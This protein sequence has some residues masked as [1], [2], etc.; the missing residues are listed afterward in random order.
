LRR[1]TRVA[2]LSVE[3]Q[4][5]A[6]PQ[7]RLVRPLEAASDE[8]ELFW[9]VREYGGQRS[10]CQSD[11]QEADLIVVQRFFPMALSAPLLEALLASGVPVIFEL[12]DLLTELTDRNPNR[13]S[14]WRSG[15]HIVDLIRRAD[16]V[17]VST[18][19]LAR[20]FSDLNRTIHVL[21][22][23]VDTRLFSRTP[24]TPSGAGT[25]RAIHLLYA[26]TPTHIEDLEM[27]EPAILHAIEVLGDRIHLTLLGCSTPLL[28]SLPQ[29]TVCDMEPDYTLYAAKLASIRADL[30]L[31]P[32]RDHRFNRCKSDIKW[33]ELS[34]LGIPG[35]YS[36]I[37]P[38]RDS[39]EHG[40]TGLLVGNE[41]EAWTESLMH[42][43]TSEALRRKLADRASAFVRRYRSLDVG[44]PLVSELYASIARSGKGHTRR[45]RCSIIVPV[46]T[47]LDCTRDC[48]S[49]L[50][51]TGAFEDAE[52]I[53]VDDGSPD[54]SA[55]ELAALDARVRVVRRPVNQGFAAA[56]NAGAAVSR[57]DLLLFLN[58]DTVPEPGWLEPLV[59]ELCGHSDVGIVGSRLLYPDRTIQHAGIAFS[60]PDGI[61][62]NLYRSAPEGFPAACERR[63]YNAVTGACMLIRRQLFQAL[64]GFDERYRNGFEDVDLCLR[65]RARGMRVVYQ[66]ESCL[67]HR[68]EQSPGRKDHDSTNLARFLDRWGTTRLPDEIPI[69]ERVGLAVRTTDVEGRAR[70]LTPFRDPDDRARWQGAAELSRSLARY[71]WDAIATAPPDPESWPND[72]CVLAWG[73]RVCRSLSLDEAAERFAVRLKQL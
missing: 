67:I 31:V 15:P 21:H 27:V 24:S 11:L 39:V 73:E 20:Y 29:T 35:I 18:F 40:V 9:G 8:L 5:A 41:P 72:V 43:L 45:P 37:R 3:D 57:G 33:L 28:A 32:L 69:L 1:P 25:Q 38:Y 71:D 30:A 6:C 54:G 59:S 2:I 68:E 4:N 14:A 26:G 7:I 34:A 12:D 19:A 36:D 44:A 60:V 49:A 13:E 23:Y 55:D 64:Q 53:L 48:I 63:E 62:Y 70:V 56:C 16:A 42:A 46:Y 17:V 66:P 51:A 22:N 10:C 47:R 65:A 61:P 50:E 58:N 52:I